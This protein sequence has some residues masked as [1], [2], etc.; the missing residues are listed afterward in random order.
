MV[1]L[2]G[3]IQPF[4]PGGDFE[5]YEDRLNQ[6]F[7]VNDVEEKKA[8]LFIT[9]AGSAIYEILKSL[10]VPDLPISKSYEELVGLLRSHF[11]PVKN[12]RA[13]RYRFYRAVQE[14]GESISE[15]IVRLKSL[16]QTC[17]FGDFIEGKDNNVGKYKLQILNDALTD[18]FII[19]IRNNKVQQLLLD[20]DKLSFEECCRKAL[21]I[22]MAEKESKAIYPSSMNS[23]NTYSSQKS[24]RHQS[25]YNKNFQNKSGNSEQQS[26][27]SSSRYHRSYSKGKIGQNNYKGQSKHK[28]GRCGREHNEENCPARNWECF[29][30]HRRGHTSIM[31]STKKSYED[32]VKSINS[33]WCNNNAS[34]ICLSVAEKE[35]CFEVD[36][37]ACVTIISKEEYQNKFCNISLTKI[38]SNILTVTGENLK[39]LGKFDAE[40]RI[41]I[42]SYI[43]PIIVVDSD[44]PFRALL[45]RNWLDILFPEWRN[46]FNKKLIN[47]V[48]TNNFLIELQ[49]K[50]PRVCQK[51][52]DLPIEGYEVDIV[53]KENSIPIFHAPYNVPYKLRDKVSVEIN[54]L[55][56]EKILIPV[57]RSR[58]ASPVVI[59]PK[60]N[61]DIRMCVDCKVTIN[62]CIESEHYPLPKL[63]DIFAKLSNCKVFCVIDLTGAYQQLALSKESQELLT[64]NTTM[65]LFRFT[66]LAFGVSTAPMI[67]QSIMDQILVGL[68]SVQ[69]F[70]DDIIIGASNEDQCRSTL[71]KVLERLEKHNVRINMEKCKFLKNEVSY[72]GHVLVNGQIKPNSEKVKA[73]VQANPPKNITQLQAFLG[74]VNFYGRFIPNLSSELS[75]LYKLLRKDVNFVWTDSCQICFEK[76]KK[77]ILS[78]NVLEL[79]D[80]EKPIILTTDASPYGVGAVLSHLVN[81]VEKPVMFA[82]SS[83]S[84]AEKNYS[85]THREALAILFGLKKF[86]NYLYGN[87]FTIYTDHHQAL[88]EIF[89]P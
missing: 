69:C 40:V 60:S 58:W 50:F 81:G 84:P 61:G 55:V 63:E 29:A 10:T 54:R 68:K 33:V 19:G 38:L 11:T 74:L 66:R 23:V 62:K 6:F 82:S 4:V 72:L 46:S 39:E 24:Q 13:E 70:L 15:F 44:K 28:C 75:C 48:R 71:Y 64:I 86:H 85:Q 88:R 79:Y 3:N 9:I 20:N 35:V 73:I 51:S 43:L 7:L 65:G 22:E 41:G 42:G 12:K 8:A 59:V 27:Q 18:R 52:L 76:C 2:I 56:S 1:S 25:K 21:N 49:S 45:G 67:F 31:C 32:N 36:T 17:Q 47:V 53:L 14:D 83:L 89:N 78:N 34:E 5:A 80:P 26:Q 57:K 77:L 30:C 87:S 16:S 37:G